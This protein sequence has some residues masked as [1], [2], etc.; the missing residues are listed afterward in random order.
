MYLQRVQIP[1]STNLYQPADSRQPRL[2][3]THKLGWL[4]VS[5]LAAQQKNSS[6][7][8]RRSCELEAERGTID[9]TSFRAHSKK[10]SQSAAS[11]I[12]LEGMHVLP[13][14]YQ[15]PR[16][17]DTHDL[18]LGSGTVL[19]LSKRAQQ[20]SSARLKAAEIRNQSLM[21]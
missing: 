3:D 21:E 13:G 11:G 9:T 10:L 7:R 8:D 6:Q 18:G 14:T 16:L 5:V 15:Q 17:V 1:Y 2:V 4:Q 12:K 20:E 19:L